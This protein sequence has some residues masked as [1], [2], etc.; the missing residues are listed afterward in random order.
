MQLSTPEVRLSEKE[1]FRLMV[2]W[3]KGLLLFVKPKP[4]D[5]DEGRFAPDQ[6]EDPALG[7]VSQPD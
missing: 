6:P 7:E 3:W 5:L 2:E 1:L 4:L